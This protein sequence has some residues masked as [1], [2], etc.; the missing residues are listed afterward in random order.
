MR[1]ARLLIPSALAL[2]AAGC[3]D[4]RRDAAREYLP[5]HP[6]E[7]FE[8]AA[9]PEKIPVV[10]KSDLAAESV[11]IVRYRLQAPTIAI[12]DALA[13]PAGQAA[14]GRV[15]E[16]RGWA[17][18]SL[19]AGNPTRDRILSASAAARTPI[20]TK[21][22]VTAAGTEIEAVVTLQLEK[23]N[24]TWHVTGQTLDTFVPGEPDDAAIPDYDSPSVRSRLAALEALADELTAMRKAYL[25]AQERIAAQSLADLRQR[26]QTGH[27]FTGRAG[28]DIPV[29]LV[30]SRGLRDGSGE[31][32]VVLT[33]QRGALASTAR[34]TG[35]VE[36]EPS[37]LHVLRA[38][39]VITLSGNEPS[40]LLG[41]RPLLTLGAAAQGV[42]L[43]IKTA[44]HAATSL[45][46]TTAPTADLIPEL[47]SQDFQDQ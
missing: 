21:R 12:S 4:P 27:T 10:K 45:L 41:Q 9:L 25:A 22:I 32:V 28:G 24:D 14:S 26:V 1:A 29:R 36:R 43:Q 39:Q 44:D 6:P 13:T 34:F 42:D 33:I 37:G 11:V 38:R 23:R 16:V 35:V 3:G 5:I 47:E 2:L 8:V 7:G 46:L 30:V 40:L 18:A 20:P 15:A 31:A 19:P 17:L